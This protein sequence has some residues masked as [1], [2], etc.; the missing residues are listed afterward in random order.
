MIM[1]G[2]VQWNTVYGWEDFTLS[3]D[4]RLTHWATEAPNMERQKKQERQN[5]QYIFYNWQT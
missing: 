3:E 1:K 4:Q 5:K 2:C